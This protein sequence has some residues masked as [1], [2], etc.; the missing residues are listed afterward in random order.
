MFLLQAKILRVCFITDLCIAA[1][2]GLPGRCRQCTCKAAELLVSHTRN[3]LYYKTGP[4]SSD[5]ALD[6]HRQLPTRRASE[7]FHLQQGWR[8]HGTSAQNGTR[9]SLLPQ[10][11]VI[12]FAPPPSPYCAEHVCIQTHT[13]IGLRTDCTWITVATKQQNREWNI[14]TQIGTGYLSLGRRPGGDW[15]NTWHW[16]ERFTVFFWTGSSN[17][18][19]YCHVLLLIALLEE[20]FIINMLY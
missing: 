17:S 19:S 16:T 10:F 2:P 13:Q 1:V 8:T 4:L 20:T 6:V 18:H 9:H 11:P 14:F 12:Y 15:A 5:A 7:F 3:A